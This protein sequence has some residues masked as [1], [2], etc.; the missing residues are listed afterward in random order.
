MPPRR[1]A[2]PRGIALLLLLLASLAEAAVTN[3]VPTLAEL[4]SH[5]SNHVAAPR[6]QAAAWG[7]KVRSLDTGRTLFE[8]DAGK[9]LSPASNSKLFTVALGFDRL[10][11]DY[12]MRTSLLARARPSAEGTLT[13]DLVVFGRGDPG[14]TTERAGGTSPRTLDALAVA[15][16]HGGVRRVQGDLIADESFLV[17]PAYGAGWAWDDL[18]YYY[19][20]PMSALTLNDNCVTVTVRPGTNAGA[21]LRV[22]ITPAGSGLSVV[23]LASTAPTGAVSTLTLDWQP[24]ADEVRLLGRLPVGAEPFTPDGTGDPTGSVVWPAVPAGPRPGRHF[25]D[26]AGT[27]GDLGGPACAAFVTDGT[28]RT[29]RLGLRPLP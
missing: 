19:G 21:A 28:R 6:F 11:S 8:H 12:R 5:F 2:S 26:R 20:A 7:V 9:L 1:L 16:T 10:G 14:F 27:R 13:G 25:R 4:R 24:G 3:P 17:G 15:L 18:R 22:Q 29:G 23:S